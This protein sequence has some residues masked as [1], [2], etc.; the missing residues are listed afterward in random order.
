MFLNNASWLLLERLLRIFGGLFVGI[1]IARY[2]GP[3]D[4]G[5]LNYALAYVAFFKVFTGL[6]LNQIVVRELVK[7]PKLTNYTLGTAFGLKFFGAFLAMIGVYAS[8]FLLQT[9]NVTKLVIFFLIFRMVFQSVDVIDYFFQAKVISKYTVIAR[10]LAF[11][12]SSLLNIYFILNEY[13]VVY[14]ALSLFIDLLLSALFLLIIYQKNDYV[15]KQWRFSKKTA[16]NLMKF[17]WPLALSVFLISIHTR[18]D[19]VMIGNMLDIEQV[20]IYSVAVKLSDAWLFF[21]GIL[22]STFMPYFISLREVDKKLYQYRLIQFYSLMFWMGVFVGLVVMLFGESIISL[23]FGEIYT[24]AYMALV[25]NIWNGIFI[26]QA[27]ARGIWMI[28]EN[29]QIYRLYSNIIVAVLNIT[30]NIL[31][32]PMYGIAGAAIATLITQFMGT[33]V[34]SLFWKPLRQ[35]SYDMIKSINPIYLIKFIFKNEQKY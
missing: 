14:F 25:F 3:K 24:D 30:I 16:I 21:P 1:W 26:S 31:L 32:I 33:W 11:L 12:C 5:I 4:F 18:I 29:L 17:A 35:S 19:Q 34:I 22:V 13:S 6:G 20:G 9:D 7:Y 28:S 23:L 27:I 10:S 8:L 15:I 2:L